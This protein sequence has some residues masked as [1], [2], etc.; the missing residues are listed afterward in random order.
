MYPERMMQLTKRFTFLSLVVLLS[1]AGLLVSQDANAASAGTDDFNDNS[2]D[3]AR[4]G[5]DITVGS[6]IL[7]ERNRRLEFS[8]TS[9]QVDESDYAFRPWIL[10]QATFSADWE[11]V[12]NV[13][14]SAS[15]SANQ[16]ALMGVLAGKD[17]EN[18]VYIELDGYRHA[19]NSGILVEADET[20]GHDTSNSTVADGAVRIAFNAK[21]KAMVVF[22]DSNGSIGGYS[23]TELA[24]FDT[25]TWG[26]G[27]SDPFV[28]G[29]YG[30]ET[31]LVVSS[32]QMYADD[33]S[34]GLMETNTAPA[35]LIQ[36]GD[37]LALDTSVSEL[38]R[39]RPSD[40]TF[41][42]IPD[43]NGT[44]ITLG[45]GPFL[46]TA[47]VQ[48]YNANS[49]S[50]VDLTNGAVTNFI[51]TP[52]GFGVL[53]LKGELYVTYSK[54]SIISVYDAAS[55]NKTREFDSSSYGLNGGYGGLAYDPEGNRFILASIFG[56]RLDSMTTNGVFSTLIATPL[57]YNVTYEAPGRFLVGYDA[58]S[59]QR[60]TLTPAPTLTPI[61]S[62][63]KSALVAAPDGAGK[64]YLGNFGG[65]GSL[66]RMNA[67]GTALEELGDPGA[68]GGT[69]YDVI[70]VNPNQSGGEKPAASHVVVAWGD[71]R[72]GQTNVPPDLGDVSAI[73]A[74]GH[75]T[76]AL[77]KDGTIAAWGSNA[78]GQTSVPPGLTQV[79]AVAAGGNFTAAL[80][81]DGTV[82]AWGRNAN[83]E[84]N[85]PPGLSGVRAIAA[86]RYEDS[87]ILALKNDGTVVG[88]GWNASF[89]VTI[90]SNLSNVIAIA[91]GN[92]HS[93]ALKSDGTV[94]AWGWNGSGESSVPPGLNGV[95]AIAAGG[96]HT[97][98]LRT[99]GTVVAWGNNDQGQTTVPAGL[100]GVVAIAAGNTHTMALKSDGTLVAWGNN[101]RGQ[102]NIPSGL[103]G[104]SAITGGGD[105]SAALIGASLLEF[106]PHYP[107]ENNADDASGGALHG[108]L[109]NNPSF[110]NG[111]SGMA[112]RL[113]GS[114][115]VQL[116]TNNAAFG[117]KTG[118]EKTISV[119][120]NL[121]RLYAD[122]VSV[123]ASR[124]VQ[125][126]SSQCEY[127]VG[128]HPS[129]V[130]IIIGNGQDAL[131]TANPIST[132]AWHHLVF[133]LKAG[134]NNSR[135]YVDG[136]LQASGAVTYN[137]EN[138]MTPVLIG[139]ISND[140][141]GYF[142]GSIDELHIY[143]RSLDDTEVTVI[144]EGTQ[145]P[146]PPAIIVQPQDQTVVAGLDAHFSV[147][148][149]G[150]APLSYQWFFRGA[151]LPGQI[152]TNLLLSAVTTNKAG[153]YTVIISNPSGSITSQVARLTVT[154]PP[155]RLKLA[156]YA[157]ITIEGEPGRTYKIEYRDA[158][159]PDSPWVQLETITLPEKTFFYLDKDSPNQPKRFYRASLLDNSPAGLVSDLNRKIP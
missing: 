85:V 141:R 32:G 92:A 86:G 10:N 16:E 51:S 130:P 76:V 17:L 4:W 79:K 2:K 95:V 143:N 108:T 100:S 132:N 115:Y 77:K 40:R 99:N 39:Y 94:V 26:L 147:T 1:I 149:E 159:A 106:N 129:G 150:S 122:Q 58:D 43:V 114:N 35:L 107:F 25:R 15:P 37:V 73:A 136:I 81:V 28:L 65:N 63:L 137:P 9:A 97:V 6:A 110:T 46:G 41:L 14:N 80:K 67:D 70:V 38:I 68:P 71:D 135:I 118:V 36:S 78:Y 48:N 123:I 90:P 12:A 52:G 89:Q 42:R 62:G 144:F 155:P 125:F 87:H 121:Q 154:I 93:V 133:V 112:I 103:S 50:R 91:A 60:L 27:G 13:H 19:F 11:I 111:V 18:Y 153:D 151:N 96:N 8:S 49:M 124:Y 98:A 29:V 145:V 109:V 59:I 69:L 131:K 102:T 117:M 45:D 156:M 128:I 134:A 82:V 126:A 53:Y 47:W 101:D 5:T 127:V 33:F 105:H 116:P 57:P 3:S 55:G 157:G 22:Y 75:H 30:L 34:A 24:S 138:T 140:P 158:L 23:W 66:R 152:Q 44:G 56:G 54:S 83:G 113:T 146:R 72:N 142:N 139:A 61:G 64:I 119:W 88:W 84:T 74:G 21:T 120:I 7:T 104:I 20:E 31:D 148:A